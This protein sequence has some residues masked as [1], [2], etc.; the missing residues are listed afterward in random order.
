MMFSR[1]F[2]SIALRLSHGYVT[3]EGKDPLVELAHTAN[4]QLS[5]TTIPGAY[6]VDLVPSS[7]LIVTSKIVEV[8]LRPL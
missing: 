4:G 8:A 6:L 7:M 2:T 1:N 5:V 3:Q